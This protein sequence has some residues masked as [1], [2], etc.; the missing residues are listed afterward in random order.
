MARARFYS[1][2]MAMSDFLK[3][4]LALQQREL[5]HTFLTLH[6]RRS[7][8][9]SGVAFEDVSLEPQTWLHVDY[10]FNICHVT[11]KVAQL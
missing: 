9:E 7:W 2:C 10:F 6:Y 5:G 4:F 1:F 11:S 8:F 3:V